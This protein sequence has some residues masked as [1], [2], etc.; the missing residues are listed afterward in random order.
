MVV[1]I[2]TAPTYIVHSLN[3]DKCKHLIVPG[4]NI[5]DPCAS[6]NFTDFPSSP[7]LTITF[8]FK[9]L[10][11]SCVA[12]YGANPSYGS[13]NCVD[14]QSTNADAEILNPCFLKSGQL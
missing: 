2:V 13:R 6:H 8:L 9:P 11:I 10:I 14:N 4:K 1:V 7:S 12:N 5:Y 3:P